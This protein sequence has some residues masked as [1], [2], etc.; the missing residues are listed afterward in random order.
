MNEE[1][2]TPKDYIGLAIEAGI[3]AIPVIGGP[4]QTLYFGRQNEKR[5]KRIEKFYESLNEDL[6]QT[7]SR[8]EEIENTQ[9]NRDQLIGILETINEEVEKARS[10]SKIDLFK[11]LYKNSLLK[12]NN[13]TWDEEE[14]FVDVLSRL[15]PLQI[16]L[17]AYL[18]PHSE[19]IENI[20]ANGYAQEFVDGSLNI[21][22][23]YGLLESKIASIVIGG[24]GKQKMGYRLSS[25]GRKFVTQT[26]SWTPVEINKNQKHNK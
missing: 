17:I 20:R 22:S 12:I 5:F 19:F 16:T 23:D 3:G 11:N 7:S 13:T 9:I 26:L 4:V 8:I 21:L 14:Y 15:T 18:I 1:N 10:Q 6:N 25:L 2:L 24:T